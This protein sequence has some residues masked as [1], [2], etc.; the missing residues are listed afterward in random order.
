MSCNHLDG[1]SSWLVTAIF[2]FRQGAFIV[3]AQQF[4][5]MFQRC[6]GA[7]MLLSFKKILS[8]SA[9]VLF[10]WII[11]LTVLPV[12]PRTVAGF[13]G[14]V[15]YASVN[16][17]KNKVSC[18]IIVAWSWFVCLSLFDHAFL[19]SSSR[20]WVDM[21]TCGRCF[22]CWL[23]SPLDSCHGGRSKIRSDDFIWCHIMFLPIQLLGERQTELSCQSHRCSY[24]RY[25]LHHRLCI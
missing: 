21:T 23:S 19:L 2:I 3:L 4:L 1:G 24:G 14:T 12:Q 20:K 18:I 11:W 17:H 10:D 8:L 25:R 13:R 16:A 22:T 6:T 9:D 7:T 15:R 5:T